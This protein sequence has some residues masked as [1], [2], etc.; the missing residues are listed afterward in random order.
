MDNNELLKINMSMGMLLMSAH[1]GM[2][3]KFLKNAQESGFDISLDQWMVLGPISHKVN[4]THKDLAEFCLKDKTSI[5]RIVNTLE[6][7][8]F[9]VRVPDQLDQRIKRVILTPQGK[10]LFKH[11]API[12]EKTRKEVKQDI[13][14]N[15]IESFKNVL[16]KINK[17]LNFEND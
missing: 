2:Y 8:K 9:V 10:E 3:R 4:P 6:K 7:R 5:S 13:P 16:I 14:D 17:N 12:M 11:T 15:E 1:R